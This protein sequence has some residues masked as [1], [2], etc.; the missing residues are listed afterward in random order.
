MRFT[1]A[2]VVLALAGC[3]DRS[4]STE[5]PEQG[6]VETKD[7]PAVPR[8]DIDILFLIDD[9]GSMKEEQDSLK[10]NFSKF[11]GVLET[12]DGGMPSVHIGVATSDLG[13]SGNDGTVAAVPGT[14]CIGHGDDGVMRTAS[15]I[16]G[17]FISDTDDGSGGRSRNYSGTLE[18]AFAA[19][20]DVG[21]NGCG[22]EQHLGAVQRALENPA[23]AG[24][25]R[26]GAYLA[27]VV[28]GDEDDCSL[29]HSTLFTS[30]MD[31]T[32]INF[33]C[34]KDGVTCDDNPDFS[35]AGKRNTCHPKPNP[36]YVQDVSRYVDFLKGLKPDPKDVIVAGIIGDPTPFEIIND[37]AHNETVLGPSCHYVSTTGTDQT[38]F[39]AVRTASFLSQFEERNTRATICQGDLSAGLTQ[40]AA[41]L[42]A[43][44]ADPCSEANVEDLDPVTPGL[45]PDCTV[46]DMRYDNGQETE[47]AVI[48]SCAISGGAV[49]CWRIEEDAEHCAYTNTDPHLK[50]V[51]DRG[52]VIPAPDI[53]VKAS[54][55]TVDP[56]GPQM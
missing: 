20:A 23:N 17:Q 52:G 18:D 27:V 1:L 2:L 56:A 43:A 34:T 39:P 22:I 11:M 29:Q 28:I 55:V 30:T 48:P 14:G 53:H 8:R 21:T 6:K 10:A 24:F 45:Q 31:P 33:E 36:T 13:S 35:I 38:A 49:P 7:I 41:L 19:I 9:S 46:S 4:L 50:L 15:M 51:V 42:T 12:L 3:P 40:V 32:A 5:V 47:L 44:L 16:N 54:C 26:D 25:L 37:T